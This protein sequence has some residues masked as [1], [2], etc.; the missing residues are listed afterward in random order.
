[1]AIFDLFSKRM[2]R[3]KIDVQEVYIYD[4]I[5]SKLRIQIVHILKDCL[6]NERE[7]ADYHA[8][9]RDG[10]EYIVDALC[11]EYG[12]FQLRES[13]GYERHVMEELFNFFLNESDCEKTLDVI[14]LSFKFID[15]Y[16]RQYDYRHRPESSELSDHAIQEL[17][18]RFKENGVG[19]QFEGGE[20]I[21]VDSQFIHAESVKPALQ[22]LNNRKYTGV[23]QEFLN[24]FEHYRH[25]RY[26]ES[27]NEAL[28]AFESTMKAICKKQRWPYS[29][30][31]TSK[32]LLEICFKNNLIPEFWQSHM[33]GLRSV[34][35]GGIPT[36]RNRL[37]GHGQGADLIEVPEHIAAYILHLTAS[38]IVYLVK[39]EQAL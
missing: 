27:I 38:T 7:F 18:A 34:L 12:V 19:Y 16:A 11:R 4:D 22:L 17:N 6:G 39:S 14:E 25:K 23:Q 5:P 15:G 9:V 32:P 36:G 2:K 13:K 31:D 33:G 3:Q 35:E 24:A 29:E 28:K 26:K 37:G 20:I 1:M 21:R 30:K 10:Y 8:Q